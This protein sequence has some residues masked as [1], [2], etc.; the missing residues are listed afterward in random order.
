MRVGLVLLAAALAA[1]AA[2]A[3]PQSAFSPAPQ[4]LAAADG[5]VN[6]PSEIL[7]ISN[8]CGVL[9]STPWPTS[10]TAR[11]ALLQRL[12]ALR[13]PCIGHAG[14]LGALGALW[15]EEGEPAQALLWLERSLLLDPSQLGTLADHALALAALG[16]GAARDALVQQWRD[17]DDIPPALR[18]RL[19]LGPEPVNGRGRATATPHPAAV[20]PPD[21]WVSYR[22]ASLLTGYETNLDHSPRL[23]E[24]T[25][26]PPDGPIT[27][28]LLT[29]LQPR[30]GAALIGELSWQLARSPAVG[31]VVQTGLQASARHAPSDSSTNWHHL[32]W[33]ASVSQRWGAWRAQAQ[34]HATWIGGSLNEPYRLAR[35]GL[36]IDREAVGCSHRLLVE[37]ERRTQQSTRSADGQA[38][39][40]LW[41]S[42]C[43]WRGG[44]GDWALG[45][46]ARIS[47]DEPI[48]S[49][50]P[51]G[52]QRHHSL[53]LRLLGTVGRSIRLD[54][55]LRASRVKDSE[56]YSPLLENNALRLLHQTQLTLELS[57][58]LSWNW[59][60]G[61]EALIQIQGVRQS[62]N[63]ELFKYSGV[64]S[65]GGLRWRW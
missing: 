22:E 46:A 19:A 25:I 24:I 18:R 37:G 61:A 13:Q 9:A 20:R 3:Q 36:S 27:L 7:R 56:G 42:M 51:G 14:F 58:T 54:A 63:L 16:E 15:L 47:T 57:R 55:S 53:G 8:Y 64:S 52:R 29:P 6:S 21:G 38:T 28:P 12:E 60:P 45:L 43:P 26:T 4:Q 39:G 31:S 11:R 10:A 30:R 41:N 59:L 40:L 49:D 35:L 2:E 32:Q 5:E 50:R 34:A 33:A 17:R 62:S 48:T 23:N 44:T 65:Y 1:L